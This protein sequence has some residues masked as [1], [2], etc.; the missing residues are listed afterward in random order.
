MNKTN[1]FKLNQIIR[2][3][4]QEYSLRD[5]TYYGSIK[6][7]FSIDVDLIND[8]GFDS[9]MLISMVIELENAFNI[10]IPDD[11]LTLD[12]LRSYN[13]LVNMLDTLLVE[14]DKV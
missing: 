5:I 14:D 3:M 12:V 13:L 1:I 9:I 4:V 6:D 2:S 11:S 8:L 10:Q 7:E